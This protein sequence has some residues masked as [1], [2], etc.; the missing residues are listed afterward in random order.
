MSDIVVAS[1]GSDPPGSAVSFHIVYHQSRLSM[2]SFAPLILQE[3][4][5]G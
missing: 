3:V 5:I 1:R 4:C 2:L